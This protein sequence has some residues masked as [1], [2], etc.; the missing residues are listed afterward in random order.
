MISLC[1]TTSIFMKFRMNCSFKSLSIASS[2]LITDRIISC[3]LC[4]GGK[5]SPCLRASVVFLNFVGMKTTETRK[6]GLLN[7]STLSTLSTLSTFV[8]P[9]EP[10]QPSQPINQSTSQPVNPKEGACQ[11][12]ITEL[13]FKATVHAHCILVKPTLCNSPS[14]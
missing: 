9:C 6:H 3:L 11:R 13:F 10:C 4:F 5:F 8:N 12:L 2:F 1:A 14:D 7:Q